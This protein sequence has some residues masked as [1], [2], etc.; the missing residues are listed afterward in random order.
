MLGLGVVAQAAE[1]NDALEAHRCGSSP[2]AFS[3]LAVTRTK[4]FSTK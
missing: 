2:K 1:V 3:Q 4:V